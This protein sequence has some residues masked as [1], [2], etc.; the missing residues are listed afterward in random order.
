MATVGAV[1]NPTKTSTQKLRLKRA[2]C[3]TRVSALA[4][5]GVVIEPDDHPHGGAWKP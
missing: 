5:L 1:S 3:V 4:L 2:A